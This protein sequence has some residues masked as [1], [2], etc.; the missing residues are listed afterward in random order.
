MFFDLPNHLSTIQQDTSHIPQG[1][2]S[3]AL[4]YIFAHRE[5]VAFVF[6]APPSSQG[7]L[8]CHE[9]PYRCWASSMPHPFREIHLRSLTAVTC[10]LRGKYI[11]T[12]TSASC[13]SSLR[14]EK[15][16]RMMISLSRGTFRQLL[17]YEQQGWGT[18][19]GA[20]GTGHGSVRMR[21][22]TSKTL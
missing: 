16:P 14:E 7:R 10:V 17:S 8:I 3:A 15:R 5:Y 22:L 1:L 20:R 18:G 13:S 21:S 2:P 4:V 9:T 6:S 11:I 19:H 12:L